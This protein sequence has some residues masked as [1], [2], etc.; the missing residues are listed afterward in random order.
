MNWKLY[1][2]LP[3][4]LVGVLTNFSTAQSGFGLRAGANASYITFSGYTIK[5]GFHAGGYAKIALSKKLYLQP[6]LIF[7]QKGGQTK[8]SKEKKY[9]NPFTQQLYKREIYTLDYIDINLPLRLN[10]WKGFHAL[11]GPQFSVLVQDLFKYNNG[12][13]ERDT[14]NF[15]DAR[16]IDFGI[17]AG[18]GYEF[19]NGLLIAFRGDAGFLK[20]LTGYD[21]KNLVASASLGYTIF[22]KR[23][24]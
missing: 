18:I 22:G 12:Y 13:Q 14:Y 6:E 24:R 21:S 17:H 5:P 10:I 4:L 7:S 16:R 19:K 8:K 9:Y 1:F 2:C 3:F 23:V 15:S 11:A 20:I